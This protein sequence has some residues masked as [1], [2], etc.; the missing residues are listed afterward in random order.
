MTA[1][2]SEAIRVLE[3]LLILC[4]DGVRRYRQ[5]AAEIPD[6]R[7][8]A[9]FVKSAIARDEVASV[10][11]SVMLGCASAPDRGPSVSRSYRSRYEAST[12][13]RRRLLRECERGEHE[14]ITA[15]TSALGRSLPDPIHA[16]VQSQLGRVLETSAALRQ[17]LASL[18]RSSSSAVAARPDPG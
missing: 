16:I 5:G 1:P 10:L 11:A 13:L 6:P 7:L 14:T 12:D 3:R 15:F 9:F 8:H 17:E 2:E 18:D 4:E